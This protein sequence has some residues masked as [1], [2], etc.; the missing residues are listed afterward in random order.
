MQPPDCGQKLA[1]IFG[2]LCH[3]ELST[4]SC[5]VTCFYRTGFRRVQVLLASVRIRVESYTWELRMYMLD[6]SRL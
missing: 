3:S 6:R 2:K 1:G 5:S 4:L